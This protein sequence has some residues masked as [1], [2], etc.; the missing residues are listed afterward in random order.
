MKNNNIKIL[1]VS[2]TKASWD[3]ND[4]K[5]LSKHFET[6]DKYIGSLKS[7]F[8]SMNPFFILKYDI[9]FF[10]FASLSFF[11]IL[12]VSWILRKKIVIIAGGFDVVKLPD[13]HYGAFLDPWPKK[14][15]RKL[16][17]FYADKVISVSYS[18]QKE[19][20][21]NAN[22][23]RSKS[24]MIYHGFKNPH[25]P[26]MSFKNRK[27]Q[28]ISIGVINNET[29][30][31]KGHIN[32]LKLAKLMP[33]WD[34]FLIGKISHDF[35]YLEEFQKCRNIS[36]P[37]FLPENDFNRFLNESKFYLQ[38]SEH[39]GFGCSIVD[40]ALMGCYPIVFDR[41]SMPE[42]VNGCGSIINFP[43]LNSVEKTIIE[44]MNSDI[45]VELIRSHYLN[46][47]PE[48]TR[49]KKLFELIS[50]MS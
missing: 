50:S 32:F 43:D 15:L 8:K 25:W 6:T 48:E 23:P 4:L 24:V 1:Y 11:P 26:L 46:K 41:Y 10:W 30:F 47:F 49:E 36:L 22:V 18:N 38:L 44:L 28:I 31:R 14:L 16:M 37:G 2:N 9:V 13:I 27:N 17:F 33:A 19:A 35:K 40:A 21:E 20:Y 5:L 39:E 7:S 12:L 29:Y 34:F 42:V 45:D 3:R